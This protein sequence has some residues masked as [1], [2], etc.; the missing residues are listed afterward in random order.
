M[1]EA[2]PGIA[3]SNTTPFGIHIILETLEILIC[4]WVTRP[5]TQIEIEY[6]STHVGRNSQVLGRVAK[7]K[8]I[9]NPSI[10]DYWD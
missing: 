1:S 5:N 10:G 7:H 8:Q 4:C 9:L 2:G 6:S 3:P